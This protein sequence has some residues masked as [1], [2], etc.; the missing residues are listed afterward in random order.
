MR[1]AT[2][3]RVC[4]A[5]WFTTLALQAVAA[6]PVADRAL[7]AVPSS[8]QEVAALPGGAWVV[9]DK[10]ALRLI[11]AQGRERAALPIRGEHLDSRAGGS[12]ALVT[13]MDADDQ[14]AL[15]I[16]V[17]LERL[18]WT[19]RATIASPDFSVEAMCQYRDT[20]G[21]DHLFRIGD[22][23]LGEQWVWRGG[24]ALL[25]RR[26]A[27]PPQTRRCRVDDAGPW[28][29]AL[30]E[31]RGVSA[32][33]AEPESL[34]GREVVAAGSFEGLA[35]LPGS[36]VALVDAS[37]VATLWRRSPAAADRS[38][39]WSRVARTALPRGVDGESVAATSSG[40]SPAGASPALAWRSGSAGWR[41]RG[42]PTAMSAPV[43]QAPALPIVRAV[44]QTDVVARFGDAA[45]D[46][47]VWIHPADPAQSRVLGTNKK[48]GLLVYD[49][50]GRQLQLLEVGR[51]NNVDVRQQVR[52]GAR[53]LDVAVA[54]QRDDLTVVVFAI[55]PRGVVREIGRV[56]TGLPDIYGVCLHRTAAGELDA[57]V[58]DKD[59]R[60]LRVR[61]EAEGERITGRVVQRFQVGSQP[62]ACV[63]DDA[64]GVLFLGE[65]KRGV[66][67]M[68]L[69]PAA[70]ASPPLVLVLPVGDLL[71][72][73][74]EGLALYEGSQG[75]YLV[76]SSQGNH[77]YVV[78]D[79]APPHRVRGA[80]R[81]GLD[82]ERGIDGAS[83]TDGL[84][85]TARPLGPAFP[86]G[87]L[88]VQDGFKRLPD[89]PQNFKLVDWRDVARALNLP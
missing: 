26:I 3:V 80:F 36:G 49:L 71:R 11:D 19:V 14:R 45:D 37:G 68:A 64:S 72:A 29:F 22:E 10:R 18:Q 40:A 43:G 42:M 44:A 86:Q 65:E 32:F 46:P 83:E 53:T 23:G 63:A 55:D 89:G 87:L 33:R 48:Q 74:V 24:S 41:S 75:R 6:P 28:L 79:A 57:F 35:V 66:W 20:Q 21:H 54:T 47:A 8:A 12:A 62:E 60:F 67:S 5:A 70:G 34:P 1:V 56:P 88:V 31:S 50:G 9:L 13:V 38:G 76:V 27:L 81:I 78:I 2:F 17:D 30:E 58:N 69:G 16:D 73:D 84:E 7:A 61:I 25:V 4:A 39:R 77:S 82:L 85:V 51:V 59:G 52:V 15:A